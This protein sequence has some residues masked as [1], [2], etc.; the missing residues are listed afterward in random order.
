MKIYLAG[1]PGAPE[2]TEH[3]LEK[4]YIYRLYTFFDLILISGGGRMK[5]IWEEKL[6]RIRNASDLS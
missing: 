4:L 1:V 3:K 5:K 2:Q 6:K